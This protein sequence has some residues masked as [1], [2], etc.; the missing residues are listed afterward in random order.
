MLL[1]RLLVRLLGLSAPASGPGIQ[2]AE[3]ERVFDPF[4]RTLGSDQVG[5]GLGLSIVK[6]VTDRI[7]AEI[8][9]DF[10]DNMSGSG[11]CVR[12]LMPVVNRHQVTSGHSR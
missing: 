3:R 12:V 6:A 8:Q 7:S 9:L 4:Y 10:A 11:L 5:S 1:K 2:I